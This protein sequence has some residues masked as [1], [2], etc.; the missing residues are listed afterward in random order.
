MQNA[1]S[2]ELV[3]SVMVRLTEHDYAVFSAAA[4]AE[5]R[6]LAAWLRRQGRLA[7]RE[8]ALQPKSV[9]TTF[10]EDAA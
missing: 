3:T 1:T 9:V 4:E 7:V 8:I 2:P 10:R 6:P 5:D